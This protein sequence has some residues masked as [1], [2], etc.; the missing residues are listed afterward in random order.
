MSSMSRRCR[1]SEWWPVE[2]R[3]PNRDHAR[4]LGRAPVG[5]LGGFRKPVG[6][7]AHALKASRLFHLVDVRLE[8]GLLGER[9][10]LALELLHLGV[11][12]VLG[13]GKHLRGV[14]F[15]VL[16]KRLGP[17][18]AAGPFDRALHVEKERR[19]VRRDRGDDLVIG[20]P[21][22]RNAGARLGEAS[23]LGA[24]DLA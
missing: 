24:G 1:R 23:A 19:Q 9:A 18:E 13:G 11:G 22:M 7:S 14:R 3:L 6:A 15:G 12:R 4:D 17:R 16:Q 21:A 8:P 5:A 2:D 10:L 20:L